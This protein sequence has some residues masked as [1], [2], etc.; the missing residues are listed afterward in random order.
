[1]LIT[2]TTAVTLP[3][4]AVSFAISST[5]IVLLE[6]VS[7]TLIRWESIDKYVLP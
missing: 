4:F 2:A 3:V 6:T 1:M 7:T 5:L